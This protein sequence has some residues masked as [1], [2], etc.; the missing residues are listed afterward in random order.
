MDLRSSIFAAAGEY[1][2]LDLIKTNVTFLDETMEGGLEE[3]NFYLFLGPAKSGKSTFLRSAAMA[4]AKTTPV[5]YVNFEQLHRN[6]T[7]KIHDMY[8]GTNFR[9]TVKRDIKEVWKSVKLMPDAPLVLARWTDKLEERMF[10]TT[11]AGP[12]KENIE[13]LAAKYGKRPVVILENFSDIYNV[14]ERG[15]NLVNVVSGTAQDIKRFAMANGVAILLAHHTAKMK[16]DRPSMDD[17]RDSKRVVDLAHSIYCLFTIELR[18]SQ[19]KAVQSREHRIAYLA[20]R[21]Q[22]GYSEA[23]VRVG[24]KMELSFE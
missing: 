7:A 21:G 18:D 23:K 3:G 16:G 13:A 10:S 19:T 15:E 4:I 20:G 9:E 1:R 5:L 14:P 24:P 11:I 17:A 2:E 12:L 8:F 22:D 6:F